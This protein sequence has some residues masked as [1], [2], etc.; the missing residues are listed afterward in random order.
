ML[1][2]KFFAVFVYIFGYNSYN[3][4]V[5]RKIVFIKRKMKKDLLVKYFAVWYNTII[6][7]GS[8]Y[9]AFI[10]KKRKFFLR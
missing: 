9:G 2:S 4:S 3:F 6:K 7:K 10:S 1:K 5:N 8:F